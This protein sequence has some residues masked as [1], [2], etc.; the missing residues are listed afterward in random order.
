M[1]P[2]SCSICLMDID[3]TTGHTTLSCDHTFHLHCITT[4]FAEHPTCPMCRDS[5]RDLDRPR[6][7]LAQPKAVASAPPLSE[8]RDDAPAAPATPDTP[9][10]PD[11]L[12]TSDASDAPSCC[13]LNELKCPRWIAILCWPLSI[14]LS[15]LIGCSIGCCTGC[16]AA[17]REGSCCAGLCLGT[18][19]GCAGICAG[20][21]IV[22]QNTCDGSKELCT[23]RQ[24]IDACATY[25]C[26]GTR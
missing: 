17:Y 16:S 24:D 12:D 20:P 22:C 3:Q 26:W 6:L 7:R 19:R 8:L 25:F 23:T 21:C 13:Q 1:S 5:G 4:W 2:T 9:D 11:T 15:P 10:T 18:V 14:T